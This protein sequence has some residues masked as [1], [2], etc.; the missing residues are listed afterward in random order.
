MK[1]M[2]LSAK[3]RHK[4]MQVSSRSYVRIHGSTASLPG[5]EPLGLKWTEGWM[6]STASLDI[7]GK[8]SLSLATEPLSS[9]EEHRNIFEGRFFTS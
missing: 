8:H 7:T 2:C 4:D 3:A 9:S 1:V 6:A 5:S